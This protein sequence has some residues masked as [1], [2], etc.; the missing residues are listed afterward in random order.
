VA[1]IF[2]VLITAAAFTPGANSE[3]YRVTLHT[4]EI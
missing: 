4:V 1:D 3:P 2:A